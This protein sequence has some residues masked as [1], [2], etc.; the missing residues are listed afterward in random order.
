MLCSTIDD[1]ERF[2]KK[3]R[4]W[5]SSGEVPD[6]AAFSKETKASKAKRKRQRASEA[7]EAEEMAEELG[8]NGNGE[9]ALKNAI[10][11]RQQARE[12]ESDN[13]LD[14]LATKYAKPSKKKSSKRRSR[15]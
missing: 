7:A 12:K 11:Q 13:F 2:A 1:E 6:Y 10:M 14:M 3:L 5:I 8:L 15:K 4:E 9:D